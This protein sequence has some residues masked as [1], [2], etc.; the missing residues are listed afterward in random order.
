MNIREFFRKSQFPVLLALGTYPL[1]ACAAAYIAPQ[2]LDYVCLYPLVYTVLSIVALVLPAKPRFALSIF[3]AALMVVPSVMYLQEATYGTTTVIA[4]LYSG[5]LFWSLQIPGWEP[6]RELGAGWIGG[7]LAI[8]LVGC[9]LAFF[10]EPIAPATNGIRLTL[11]LFVF[12]AMLSLNR[13]SLNLAS[14][15]SRG[16][17]AAMQR[18]NLLLTVGMFAIALLI[19]FIPSLFGL[20]EIFLRW[21]GW[22]IGWLRSIL[23]SNTPGETTAET[24]EATTMSTLGESWMDVVLEDKNLH[25]NYA[26]DSAIMTAIVVIILIPA[27][28]VVLYK[29]GNL[30]IKGMRRLVEWIDHT[31]NLQ[32]VDFVDEITDTRDEI[33]TASP[34]NE[35]KTKHRILKLGK[36]TPAERIRYRY[37]RLREKHPEWK[38]LCYLFC[39]GLLKSCKV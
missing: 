33:M 22:L 16:F 19:A 31:A 1:G 24:T 34:K 15:G 25:S 30:L 32:A 11:L 23:A 8:N 12:F 37:R 10:E 6:E 2:L 7:G 13:G 9:F 21:I 26:K 38:N 35:R 29:V 39:R 3:G 27:A 5:L 28:F 36:M 14:A 4:L 20:I 18:K 17:T